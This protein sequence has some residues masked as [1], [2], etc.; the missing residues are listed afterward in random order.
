MA[1]KLVHVTH[2]R[3]VPDYRLLETFADKFESNELADDF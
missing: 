1:S 3:V 2:K